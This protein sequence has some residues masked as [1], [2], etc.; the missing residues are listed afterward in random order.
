[1]S[2]IYS[3]F[4]LAIIFSA[5]V[6][7]VTLIEVLQ[8]AGA[9]DFAAQIESDPTVSALFSSSQVQTVFAPIDGSVVPQS[10][11][12]AKRQS[13]DINL[14][15]HATTTFNTLGEM[16]EGSGLPM[17]SLDNNA[18]LGGLGQSIVSNPLN[19]IQNTTAKRWISRSTNT[20]SKPS[21]LKIFTGLGNNVS[22]V[23]ADVPYDGGLVHVI[24]S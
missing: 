15:F 24:D 21:L 5:A 17:E 20:T 10:Q 9:S 3:L 13:A 14:R 19:V 16:S 6:E 23:Q 2:I 18:N 22:I 8:S 4:A 12:K 7:A 11:R 1:M